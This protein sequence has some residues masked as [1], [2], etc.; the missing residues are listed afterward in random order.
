MENVLLCHEEGLGLAVHSAGTGEA[1]VFDLEKHS[2]QIIQ[3]AYELY[4]QGGSVSD[5][6]RHWLKAQ[7]GG[8]C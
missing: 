2:W 7:E 5:E 3:K 8:L 1:A 4:A 6:L